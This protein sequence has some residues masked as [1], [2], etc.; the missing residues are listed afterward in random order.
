MKTKT[1]FIY[2]H[3]GFSTR[4]LLRSSI[5]KQFLN[6]DTKLN[7]VILSHNGNEKEFIEEFS[8]ANIFVE[9]FQNEKCSDYLKKNKLQRFFILLRSFVL[10]GK[11]DTRTIDDFRKIFLHEIKWKYEYGFIK[12][13]KGLIFNFVVLTL[14]KIKFFRRLLVLFETKV[15]CP[16]FHE[17]LFKKYSPDLVV[18]TALCGFNYNELFAR[19]AILNN[20]PV[21]SVILSWDNTT[22]MGMRGYEPDYVISWTKLMKEELITLNDIDK[23]KIYVG[24]IAHFDTYYDKKSAI[25]RKS[26]YEL[27]GLDKNKKTIFF[28][29]KSPKRFPWGPQLVK[30][31]AEAIEN[32]QINYDAQILV[33]IHPLHYRRNDGKYIFKKIID[34]YNTISKKYNFIVVNSP[35][36]ISSKMDFNMPKS[37][38]P[39]VTSILTHSDVMLNMFSTMVIE[40]AIFNLPSINVCIRELCKADYGKSK[41]DIMVDYNQT[42]NKRVVDTGGVR[43]VFSMTEM[44]KTINL[45]LDNPEIDNEQRMEIVKNEVGDFR[46]N[47]GKNI[48]NYIT[49]L[50]K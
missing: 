40:S 45:Y 33:R 9:K 6:L 35:Q 17:D 31:L 29:T 10:N 49:A 3:T 27:M 12:G 8:S 41:Q 23:E 37:E 13:F 38:T 7:F 39:L 34:E 15:F 24:G 44:Y 26:F 2:V 36:T 30:K 5:F 1:I 42:H 14:K 22:G 50:V 19:E 20:V 47:A 28:A 48:A 18:T 25:D 21:C 43:T 32:K 46:G 11:Y 4:Y 16:S